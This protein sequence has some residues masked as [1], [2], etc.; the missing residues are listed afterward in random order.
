MQGNK[1]LLAKTKQIVQYKEYIY[2]FEKLNVRFMYECTF[3]MYF[4]TVS[5]KNS[6]KVTN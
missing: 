2:F 3:F 5:Y 4:C 6:R 1:L